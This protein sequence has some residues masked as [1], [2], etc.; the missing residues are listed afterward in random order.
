M[1]NLIFILTILAIAGTIQGCSKEESPQVWFNVDNN[2]YTTFTTAVLGDELNALPNQEI[3]PEEQASLQFMREEEKL[4]HD[5]YIKLYDLWAIQAF[6]HIAASEQTHTDAVLLLLQKYG[7]TDPA[8]GQ[9]VGTFVNVDLQKLYQDLIAEGSASAIAALR[10][11]ALVEEVDIRD[12][13][14]ALNTIDNQ[15]IIWVYQNL[16]K[17][18]RNHLRAFVR[19]LDLRGITYVPQVLSQEAFDE[20]INSETETGPVG[21]S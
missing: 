3:S 14:V 19:N 1:K 13:Q 16:M 5:V 18:S 11:G 4:A 7:L 12:I 17:G 21:K 20:I 6:D 8:D 9:A 15:D 2:G 10:V